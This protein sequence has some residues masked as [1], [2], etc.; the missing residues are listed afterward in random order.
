MQFLKDGV[1]TVVSFSSFWYCLKSQG[2]DFSRREPPYT[3]HVP[4]VDIA[5]CVIRL[6]F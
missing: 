4:E 2:H 3:N 5:F 6:V 1:Q